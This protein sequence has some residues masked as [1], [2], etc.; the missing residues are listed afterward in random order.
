MKFDVLEKYTQAQRDILKLIFQKKSIS[1]ADIVKHTGISN[2]T[3]I[4][5]VKL[6]L[7]DGLIVEKSSL[8]SERG[9]RTMQLSVNPHFSYFLCVDIGTNSTKIAVVSFNCSIIYQ[10]QILNSPFAS[11]YDPYITVDC[12]R[13][14]L[15]RVLMQYGQENFSAIC[16]SISGIVDYSQK[17]VRFCA[18][19]AGW[20]EVNLEEAFG[21]FFNLPIYLDTS[22]HCF[23]L[24]ENHFCDYSLSSSMMFIAIGH[25]ISTGLIFNGQIYRGASGAAGEMGHMYVPTSQIYHDPRDTEVNIEYSKCSCGH[26]NCLELYTTISM[27]REIAEN[28]SRRINGLPSDQ[29]VY[30][31]ISSIKRAYDSNDEIVVDTV[32][33]AAH[34]L[35]SIIANQ[36]NMLNPKYIVLGGGTIN[37]FP[38]IAKIV[39]QDVRR[40]SLEIISEDVCVV[41]SKLGFEGATLGAA[42]LAINNI[43]K[44]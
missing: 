6:L 27:I 10:A 7:Q 31:T 3:T 39:E 33:A 2:L 17:V 18:N 4:N 13:N 42:L 34:T 22:G 40:Y 35:G 37:L 5:T 16:F 32:T 41:T 24:A 11:V 1:R 29:C 20:N 30:P 21:Q 28:R 12:L 44:I 26:K 14:E 9:R 15:D 43:L 25:S 8:T 23:A 36:V 38:E 19:I